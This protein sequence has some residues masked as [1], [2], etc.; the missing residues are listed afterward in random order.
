MQVRD[1]TGSTPLFVAVSCD[2]GDIAVLLAES[3]ADLEVRH[4][5]GHPSAGLIL[6]PPLSPGLIP[7]APDA[8]SL[9]NCLLRMS[10]IS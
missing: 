9:T 4:I 2:Q 10:T 1:K 7:V 6:A 5:P 3:G 8:G